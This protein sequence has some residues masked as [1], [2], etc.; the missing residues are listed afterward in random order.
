MVLYCCEI[1]NSASFCVLGTVHQLPSRDVVV[2]KILFDVVVPYKCCLPPMAGECRFLV[3]I[4]LNL[5]L[6]SFL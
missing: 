4:A 6:L 5:S 3:T 2:D 1:G